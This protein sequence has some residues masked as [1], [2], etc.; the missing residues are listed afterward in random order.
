MHALLRSQNKLT[1]QWVMFSRKNSLKPFGKAVRATHP[2]NLIHYGDYRPMNVKSCHDAFYCL[3]HDDYSQ[4]NYSYLVSHLEA[5]D[6]S[7]V[8]L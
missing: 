2:L 7:N 3:A 6:A 8:F 4:Q 1:H 5:L